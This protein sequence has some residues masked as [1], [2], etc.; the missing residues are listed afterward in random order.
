MLLEQFSAAKLDDDL[1]WELIGKT[2]CFHDPEF[3]KPNQV[4]GCRVRITFDD[5]FTVE[6]STPWP[7]G[8]DPPISNEDIRTKWRKLA[9]SVTDSDRMQKI[10]DLILNL[11]T[12]DDT[13]ISK[14]GELLSL[15]VKNSMA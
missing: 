1:V 5:G 14:L 12:A 9:S 2:E 11:D 4:A 13:A 10:E 7:K 3:D 8:Y 6:E 15:P